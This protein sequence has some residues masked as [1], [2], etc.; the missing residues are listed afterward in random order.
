MKYLVA[1][2]ALCAA[3]ST[4]QAQQREYTVC[5]QQRH[6]QNW[7]AYVAKYQDAERALACAGFTGLAPRQV[8]G[9]SKCIDYVPHPAVK[10]AA[11]VDAPVRGR[12]PK[13]C[14]YIEIPQNSRWYEQNFHIKSNRSR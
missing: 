1:L 2:F 11:E 8:G 13:L 14:S 10:H 7:G 9:G 12:G 4:A 3:A 6:Q 5:S